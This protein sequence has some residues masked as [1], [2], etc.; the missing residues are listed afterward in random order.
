MSKLLYGFMVTASLAISMSSLPA[1][2]ADKP[3]ATVNNKP[4]SQK[5]Y[6]IYLKQVQQQ[7]PKLANNR[8]MI[9]KDLINQ[10]L[11][12]QD[13]VKK[14]LAKDSEV[15]FA[16][17]QTRRRTL[18]QANLSK[19]ATANPITDEMVKKEYDSKIKSVSLTE[20]KAQHIMLKTEEEAKA[21]IKELDDGAVFS[22]IAN[23][24]SIDKASKGGDL[25]WF[26][27]ELMPKDFGNAVKNIK[28][29]SY[30]QTPIK[31]PRGWHVIRLEDT[32]QATPPKLK[33]VQDRL[34][35]LL[36]NQQLKEY[37]AKLEKKAKIKITKTK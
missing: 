13:A 18:I 14:K 22:D 30:S 35:S 16:L 12:Y 6:S 9:L 28:K 31:T 36:R 4:I 8:E 7:Q 33:Q 34:R 21:V 20:Y 17:E 32:R 19:V 10:E 3:L 5:L 11:L 24:K 37:V 27:A 1:S 2:A 23:S 29:G 25:G 15:A 26:K